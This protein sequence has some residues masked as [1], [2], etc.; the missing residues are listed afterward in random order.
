MR[1]YGRVAGSGEWVVVQTAP[2]GD[3]SAV[4]LTN[5]IQVLKLN[6]QESP[7][8]ANYGIPAVQTLETQIYPDYYVQQVQ[9]QFAQFF[10]TLLIS[11]VPNTT[12]PV[13]NITVV[14]KTGN[15]LSLQVPG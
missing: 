6:L 8:Y 13:Y 5:L 7:F 3:N 1:V 11:K 14:T 2:N 12:K 10:T 9:S 4:Y 15:T